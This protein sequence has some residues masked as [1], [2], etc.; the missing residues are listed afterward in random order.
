M[1]RGRLS[2]LRY[3]WALGE[4]CEAGVAWSSARKSEDLKNV[5]IIQMEKVTALR[6]EV[7]GWVEGPER[8]RHE[9]EREGRDRG[10]KGGG[11][12]RLAGG[13]CSSICLV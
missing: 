5:G 6:R 12:V 8:V 13:G 9:K 11:A 4:C 1:L 10:R 3:R 7:D 2:G